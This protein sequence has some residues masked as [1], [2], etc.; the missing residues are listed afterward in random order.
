M[1]T[2][3]LATVLLVALCAAAC[4]AMEPGVRLEAGGKAIDAPIGHLVPCALDW[5][6]DGKKDLVVGLFQGGKVR[7]Y[8]N[9]GTDAA[10]VFRGFSCL[11]AGAADISLPAG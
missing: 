8:L 2:G 5:N 7:L 9:Q 10:P 3:M 6:G 1:R 4:A 11:Q